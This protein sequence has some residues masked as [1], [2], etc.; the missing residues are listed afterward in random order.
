[1]TRTLPPDGDT[2]FEHA[3]M[4]DILHRLSV[5]EHNQRD[6]L[7]LLRT[8][9]HALR[10]DRIGL[11]GETRRI[12]R[13]V[14]R[15]EPFNGFCPCCLET[16]VVDDDGRRIPPAEYDHFVGSSYNAPVHS[17][18]ICRPCHLD[19]T[20]D[21]HLGWYRQLTMRFRR[22]QAAVA[23]Y[24]TAFGHRTPARLYSGKLRP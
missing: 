2:P 3:Q 23:A 11:S 20:N 10:T 16:K 12:H 21:R 7:F 9:R 8:L 15:M 19:L 13:D 1:M 22:Y 17:W 18:L 14:V 4:R 6:M 24:A 5:L